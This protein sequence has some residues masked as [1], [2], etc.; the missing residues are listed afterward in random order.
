L[1]GA[2]KHKGFRNNLKTSKSC[3]APVPFS[4]K[5]IGEKHVLR[6]AVLYAG[7]RTSAWTTPFFPRTCNLHTLRV[8]CWYQLL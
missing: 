8:I 4:G 6:K 3:H 1:N 7:G 5:A 2:K